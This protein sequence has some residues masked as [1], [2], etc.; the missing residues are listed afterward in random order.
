[1]LWFE[2]GGK[3]AQN[4]QNAKTKSEPLNALDDAVDVSVKK[5]KTQFHSGL[6]YSSS[7]SSGTNKGAKHTHAL[8]HGKNDRNHAFNQDPFGFGLLWFSFGLHFAMVVAK[9]NRSKSSR[10]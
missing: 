7:V 4:S 3:K 1:M 5:Q 8:N 6:F 9:A 2:G 10:H